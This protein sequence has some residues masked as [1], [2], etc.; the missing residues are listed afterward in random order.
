MH[1]IGRNTVQLCEVVDF[2]NLD[3]CDVSKLA[4]SS[5]LIV[6]GD[7]NCLPDGE[8][9]FQYTQPQGA[10]AADM[11]EIAPDEK[12]LDEAEIKQLSSKEPAPPGTATS[13]YSRY[14]ALHV[15]L[16][17]GESLLVGP[18]SGALTETIVFMPP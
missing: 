6:S 12:Q 4:P 10:M 5:C 3:F 15:L 7:F 13:V 14:P 8:T 17:M 11:S 2:L 1:Q 9:P 16:I 18:P